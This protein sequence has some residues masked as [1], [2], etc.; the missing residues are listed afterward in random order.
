MIGQLAEALATSRAN[1]AALWLLRNVPGLPPIAQSIHIL[2]IAAVMAS[3]FM[4]S[5]KLVGLALPSQSVDSLVRRLMPWTYWALLVNFTTGMLFVIAQPYRYFF[6]PVFAWKLAF[7]LPALVLAVVVHRL[8]LRQE[9]FWTKSGSRRLMGR[10]LGL[11]SVLFWVGVILA[12]R[13]IAY[14]DYLFWSE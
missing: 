5:L 8:T 7:L 4:V 1:E 10:G 3:T 14:S 13:W 11:L 2:G 12:G 9:N 6:N